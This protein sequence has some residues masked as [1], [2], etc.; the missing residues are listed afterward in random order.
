MKVEK[1]TDNTYRVRKVYKGRRYTAYFDHIPDEREVMIIMSEKLQNTGFGQDKA[2]FGAY[3]NKYI[4]SKVNVSKRSEFVRGQTFAE[5]RT[6][7]SRVHI[8]RFGRFS[9]EYEDSYHF[10]P[11]T[12]I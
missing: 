5:I 11:K 4:E 6:Q 3:C 7:P 8:C 12:K 9:S 2:S 10:T 1:L